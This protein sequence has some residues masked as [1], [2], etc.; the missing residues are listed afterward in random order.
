MH[1]LQISHQLQVPLAN[2]STYRPSGFANLV[3]FPHNIDEL[4][5]LVNTLEKFWISGF[6]ANTLFGSDQ[7]ATPIISTSKLNQLTVLDDGT[8]VAQ[9][10]V[11]MDNMIQNSI[12]KSF[13]G[14]E[15]LSGIPGTVGGAIWMNAGAYGSEISD[16]LVSVTVF[17]DNKIQKL[18]KNQC[19]FSY[20]SAKMLQT[21]IILDATFKLQTSSENLLL[22]RNDIL[23]N[24]LL[25]QPLDFPS[26]GSVFKRPQ[27]QFASALIDQA[28]LKGKTI[29][30]A[31]VSEKH[32]G[33]IINIGNA[34][35]Q[36][37]INL[38]KFCQHTVKEKFQIDLQLEQQIL[39]D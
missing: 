19:L 10:G 8:I 35:N 34:S 38:I 31:Q 26:C 6:G 29:G 18:S 25:K 7:I 12:K 20:R 32:A 13:K 30:G 11:I 5:T 21:A 16:H 9:A 37:I 14:F 33:F 2:L 36:D 24:R 27:G 28:N 3:Y 17:L 15:N 22:I 23:K 1:N 39:I 4:L